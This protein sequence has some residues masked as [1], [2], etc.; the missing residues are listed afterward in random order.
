MN[1]KDD[2]GKRVHIPSY[3]VPGSWCLILSDVFG[4]LVFDGFPMF[5]GFGFSGFFWVGGWELGGFPMFVEFLLF[6]CLKN[7]KGTRRLGFS[8]VCS[9]FLFRCF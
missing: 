1:Y 7:L 2:Q 8:D 5:L 9:L 4:D 6:R 3:P